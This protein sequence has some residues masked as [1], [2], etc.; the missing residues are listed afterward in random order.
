[1]TC[2]KIS[3]SSSENTWLIAASSSASATRPRYRDRYTHSRRMS[4]VPPRD[5]AGDHPPE[6]FGIALAQDCERRD[7]PWKLT[8]RQQVRRA[9]RPA[10]PSLRD[11]EGLVE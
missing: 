9:G 7:Q 5:D 11:R 1:M 2:R 3:G 4:G 6:H 8:M 10:A